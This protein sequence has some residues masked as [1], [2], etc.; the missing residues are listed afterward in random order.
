MVVKAGLIVAVFMHMA[1]ERLALMYAILVPP[2]AVLLFVAIM[3]FELEYTHFIRVAFFGPGAT[4]AQTGI[5]AAPPDQSKKEAEKHGLDVSKAEGTASA[6]RNPAGVAPAQ[7]DI[8][9]AAKAPQSKVTPCGSAIRS[10]RSPKP[11]MAVATAANIVLSLKPT[12]PC[13]PIQASSVQVRR[14]AFRRPRHE[15]DRRCLHAYG[16]KRRVLS[17]AILS[18]SLEPMCLST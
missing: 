3:A 7:S 14:F 17:C 18:E 11:H 16:L 15:I 10:G 6:S 4:S 9:A 1:W 8:A 2:G 5:A 13:C 12:S